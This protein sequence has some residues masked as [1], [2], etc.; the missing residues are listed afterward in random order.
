M[1]I[2]ITKD[3]IDNVELVHLLKSHHQEMLSYSPAESVHALDLSQ[4]RSKDIIFWT[5]WVDDTLA[6]CGALKYLN[7]SHAEIKSMRTSQSYLRKGVAAQL[8]EHIL[9]VC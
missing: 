9:N 8:L 3:S 4:L 1:V 7:E 2:T 5:A 6:G